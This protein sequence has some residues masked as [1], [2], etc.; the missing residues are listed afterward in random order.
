M[1]AGNEPC[2][3]L[4]FVMID[5]LYFQTGTDFTKKSP[6]SPMQN[7]EDH[8]APVTLLFTSWTSPF[9]P[10]LHL[11]TLD[12]LNFHWTPHALLG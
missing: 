3:F 6:S 10:L 4:S 2:D 8:V 9:A 5:N 7:C 1:I 12:S 11:I